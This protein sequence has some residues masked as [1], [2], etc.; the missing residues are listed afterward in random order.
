[1]R[2][3]VDRYADGGT[4]SIAAQL[5][6]RGGDPVEGD[7]TILGQIYVRQPERV[8]A[9]PS[10][11]HEVAASFDG[12]LRL[13]GYDLTQDDTTLRLTLFW[14][15]LTRMGD[16]YKV[17]VHVLDPGGGA[18][19]AQSDVVPRGWSYP[20][21]R[22]EAGEVVSDEVTIDVEAVPAGTYEMCIGAYHPGSG[23]RLEVTDG[24]ADG[25]RLCL[26]EVLIP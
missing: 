24:A 20:T 10:P 14:Q 9:T 18:P 3:H 19:V 15:A 25:D 13:I 7:V 17:F 4:Y 2:L 5:A 16:S 8:F 22:W 23:D 26:G 12:K 1:V 21:T 11:A 6:R